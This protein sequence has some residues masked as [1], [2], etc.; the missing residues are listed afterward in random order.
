MPTALLGP[1][2]LRPIVDEILDR[3]G[4]GGRGV[5]INAGW[6]E[7]EPEDEELRTRL[8]LDL[9]NLKLW[10]R[11]SDLRR[12]PELGSLAERRWHRVD[13]LR[14][15]YRR[16]LDHALGAAKEL[17]QEPG[18]AEIVLPERQS[19]IEGV[20][21]LDRHF[22]QR[23]PALRA[24]EE[25]AWDRHP[26]VERHRAELAE[27]VARADYVLLA[28]GHVVELLDR[29][30]LFRLQVPLAARPVVAWSAGAM[31]LTERVVG[32]HDRPPQG[33][34]NAEILDLGLGRC[35]GIVVLPHARRRLDLE[36]GH[37]VAMMARRFAPADCLAFDEGAWIHTENG[38]WTSPSGIRRLE[39]DGSIVTL[40]SVGEAA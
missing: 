23:L 29:L 38:G 19:S 30:R 12:D 10:G 5:L 37:R 6:L 40:E 33:A 35:R 9:E 22:A 17:L 3:L 21:D 31:A 26:E 7:R 28:G 8:G 4:L 2:R 27:L 11:S 20:R 34:G 25:A 24:E 18:E 13:E 14:R 36:D 1:Q 15:L 16:R 32:F 39:T